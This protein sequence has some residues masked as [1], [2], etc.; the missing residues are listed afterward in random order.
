MVLPD[1]D[2]GRLL[3]RS[4]GT[5][6]ESYCYSRPEDGNMWLQLFDPLYDLTPRR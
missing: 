3:E 5:P 1:W 2:A 6:I 4:Q